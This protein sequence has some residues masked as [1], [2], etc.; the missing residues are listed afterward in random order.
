[1][2]EDGAAAEGLVVRMRD[3]DEQPRH[4]SLAHRMSPRKPSREPLERRRDL[5]G[6]LEHREVAA[7]LEPLDLKPRVGRG[8]LPLG[9]QQTVVARLGVQ[10]ERR[11]GGSSSARASSGTGWAAK[12]AAISRPA[13]DQQSKPYVPMLATSCSAGTSIPV[14]H[15]SNSPART[16]SQ[17]SGR[18]SSA[19][20]SMKRGGGPSTIQSRNATPGTPFGPRRRRSS[21]VTQPA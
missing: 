7:R 17:A 1:M 13:R 16:A 18:W 20:A 5:G 14:V 2:E 12:A 15:M 11:A 4:P 10:V 19:S 21:M 8:V 9:G 3:D 6:D